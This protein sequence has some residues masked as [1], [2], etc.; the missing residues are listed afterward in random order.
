MVSSS[1]CY[2]YRLMSPL[3]VYLPF[4]IKVDGAAL[5]SNDSLVAFITDDI[6]QTEYLLEVAL[7]ISSAE[8][9]SNL[10]FYP[11]PYTHQLI[12]AQPKQLSAQVLSTEIQRKVSEA[13]TIKGDIVPEFDWYENAKGASLPPVLGGVSYRWTNSHIDIAFVTELFNRL[14]MLP[15]HKIRGAV[16]SLLSSN[17][18]SCHFQF[19]QQ[20]TAELLDALRLLQAVEGFT[21]GSAQLAN[22]LAQLG[23]SAEDYVISRHQMSEKIGPKDFNRLFVQSCTQL[24]KFLMS[25]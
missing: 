14:R 21:V 16:F 9:S 10:R 25:L 12:S 3:G 6:E 5:V 2:H 17:Q 4:D 15:R 18:L 11:L 8:A 22:V 20:A 19:Q 1:R 24:R 23:D 13:Y 7:L